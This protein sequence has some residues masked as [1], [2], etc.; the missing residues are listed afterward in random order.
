MMKIFLALLGL[1]VL[2]SVA[3]ANT[4]CI[5]TGTNERGNWHA[6]IICDGNKKVLKNLGVEAKPH[7]FDIN[8]LSK[9]IAAGE[10]SRGR[11]TV[12]SCQ[13]P[14]NAYFCIIN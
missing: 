8:I 4:S 2:Q 12:T 3:S 7:T 10:L 1:L 5:L 13:R 11:G 9:M 14:M 6:S